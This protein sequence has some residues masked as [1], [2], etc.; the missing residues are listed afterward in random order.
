MELIFLKY[1]LLTLFNLERTLSGFFFFFL[2]G[3]VFIFMGF[4]C[5]KLKF[6]FQRGIFV[7]Y[8]TRVYKYIQKYFLPLV[9]LNLKLF[10]V[11]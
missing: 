6:R 3:R 10:E 8:Y 7:A 1:V 11:V 9:L 5:Y 4:F 2:L